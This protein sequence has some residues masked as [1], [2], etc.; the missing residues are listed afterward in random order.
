MEQ[1]L[2]ETMLRHTEDREVTRDSHNGFTKAKSCLTNRVACYDRMT[3]SVDNGR[4]TTVIY[5]GFHKAFDMVPH[6]ILFSKLE[7][8]GFDG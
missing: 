8:H 4:A 2:L 3:T 1:I 5:L 6:N 7:R